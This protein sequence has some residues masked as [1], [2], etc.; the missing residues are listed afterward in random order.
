MLR[1]YI[2]AEASSISALLWI[3]IGIQISSWWALLVI[4]PFIGNMAISLRSIKW[5]QESKEDYPK[6]TIKRN[7]DWQRA[8]Y[9]A[10]SVDCEQI[11]KGD[12][13]DACNVSAATAYQDGEIHM[14]S[15]IIKALA[16]LD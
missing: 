7:L 9:I 3:I 11:T 2:D 8:K 4:I 15:K 5:I 13:C 6:D 12:A 14:R 1:N 10:G 16:E